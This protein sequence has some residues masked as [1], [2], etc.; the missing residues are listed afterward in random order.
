MSLQLREILGGN[1]PKSLAEFID[2]IIGNEDTCLGKKGK[3]IKNE[4][5]S[6]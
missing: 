1:A 5:L 3:L 2:R 6:K 4:I